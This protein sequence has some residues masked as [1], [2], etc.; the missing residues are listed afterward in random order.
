MSRIPSTASAY[1]LLLAAALSSICAAQ[2]TPPLSDSPAVLVAG[3]G[4]RGASPAQD[5]APGQ[6]ML[7]SV[8]GIKT[9]I[10]APEVAIPTQTGLPTN[11]RGISVDLVQGDGTQV[12]PPT[13]TPVPLR[14]ISQATCAIA[15]ACNTL[16]SITLQVPFSLRASALFP[17]LRISEGGKAVGAVALRPVGDNIHVMNT[18]DAT[19]IVVGASGSAPQ[20][21]CTPAVLVNNRGLNSLYNLVRGGDQVA[22]WA[23]GLGQLTANAPAPDSPTSPN[24]LF[25][26]TKI[27]LSF[28]FRPNALAS[29]IVPGYGLT[30]DPIYAGHVGAGSYQINFAIPP[31][32][33][34]VPACDGT[35]IRSNLTVTISAA[36]S[37]DAAF[38]CVQP[39]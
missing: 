2:T 9:E 22:M 27:Q 4:Y 35:T 21:I 10:R 36:N 37:H 12:G 31:V 23:F 17:Y 18:C 19:Q 1:V 16:T 32:P 20:N 6:V 3:S 15:E 29:P 8:Y 38:L 34:G 28:D 25:P 39:Q 30:A 26:V 11:I 13:V 5:A 14:A 7:I 24:D 33:P